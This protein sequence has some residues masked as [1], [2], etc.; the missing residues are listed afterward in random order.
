MSGHDEDN[1][2]LRDAQAT[3]AAEQVRQAMADGTMTFGDYPPEQAK[4]ILDSLP[5]AEGLDNATV[6]TSVRLPLP[7]HQKLRAYAE[8]HGTTS[9]AL[10]RQW[11]EQMLTV[12]DRPISLADALRALS[13]LPP[14]GRQSAA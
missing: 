13:T 9:S 12:P 2:V 14:Q 6:P 4:A 3:V 7:L 5:P 11:V 10:I 8:E 1:Q